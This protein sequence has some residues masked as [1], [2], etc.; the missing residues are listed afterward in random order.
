MSI[1]AQYRGNSSPGQLVDSSGNGYDLV[2]VGAA[3]GNPSTPTP[4]EGDRWLAHV[5]NHLATSYLKAPAAVPSAITAEGSIEGYILP[6]TNGVNANMVFS[7]NDASGAGVIGQRFLMA[8]DPTGYP[9]A[10]RL[11]ILQVNP[12][13]ILIDTLGHPMDGTTTQTF[14]VQWGAFGTELYLDGALIGSSATAPT[15]PTT[16]ITLAGWSFN[17]TADNLAESYMDDII[18]KDT[19]GAAIS[20][21]VLLLAERRRNWNN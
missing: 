6:I 1:I 11:Y 15:I 21:G 14:K 16:D 19:V 18:I 4:P 10:F 20:P 3:V 12:S 8:I 2:T 7:V 5:A 9:T 17:S 13:L